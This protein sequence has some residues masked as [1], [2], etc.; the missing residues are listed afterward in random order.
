MK[1]QTKLLTSLILLSL[2]SVSYGE[3]AA[4][5]NT[6]AVQLRYLDASGIAE[7]SIK[8]DI[9]AGGNKSIASR[10][11]WMDFK[12]SEDTD[13]VVFEVTRVKANY[14]AH[15]MTQRLPASGLR[16]Q[17]FLMQKT[18]NKRALKRTDSDSKL[19]IGVGQMIGNKYPIGL[20][21]T[22]FMPLLPEEAVTVGSTWQSTKDTRWLEGWAWTQ[23]QLTTEHE[24]TDITESNGHTIVSVSSQSHARLRDVEGGVTYSGDGELK[25]NANWRFDASDGRLLS[26]SIEQESTGINTLP[27]GNIEVLQVTKLQYSTE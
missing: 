12:L 21:V 16:G 25:R 23:G 13:A 19:E 14:E 27:Q 26:M 7:L 20:A 2:S 3:M 5:S 9:S 1:T 22:E 4:P 18:D 10:D 8:Q 15:G 24:V 6:E 11:F 17:S